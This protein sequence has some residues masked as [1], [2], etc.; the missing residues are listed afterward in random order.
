VGEVVLTSLTNYAM[1]LIRYRIGDMA[2]WS[3]RPCSCGRSWPLL[4]TVSGRVTDT[5]IRADGTLVHG[6]YF[7]HLFYFRDWVKKFQVVQE[8]HDLIKVYIVPF[9]KDQSVFDKCKEEIQDIEKKIGVV[10]GPSC[11]VYWNL[12]SDIP[13]TASGKYRY[14]ISN[15][16]R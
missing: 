15:V 9:N 16:P 5:F 12:L 13:P 7:A 4:K 14:T 11:K 1:P 8:K 6:E 3:E 10:M 2:A